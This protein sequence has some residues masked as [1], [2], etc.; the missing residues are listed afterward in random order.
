VWVRIQ[1]RENSKT[2][3]GKKWYT[4]P[5]FRAWDEMDR[6]LRRKNYAGEGTRGGNLEKGKKKNKG[7]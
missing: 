3:G 1:G 5:N 6:I 4:A 2:S 7:T